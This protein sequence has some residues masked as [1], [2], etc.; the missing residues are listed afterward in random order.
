[1]LGGG[2]AP[3]TSGVAPEQRSPVDNNPPASPTA[4]PTAETESD[5]LPF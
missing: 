3:G 1:M 5:D 2:G 4:S